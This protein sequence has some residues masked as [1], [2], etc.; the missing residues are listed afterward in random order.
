MLLGPVVS[1]N[2]T[3]VFVRESETQVTYA[4]FTLDRHGDDLNTTSLVTSNFGTLNLAIDVLVSQ[5]NYIPDLNEESTAMENVDFRLYSSDECSLDGERNGGGCVSFSPG[6][7]RAELRVEILPD[8]V[9]EGNEVFYLK[10]V[11]VRNGMRTRDHLLFSM[12]VT[13]IDGAQR[14]FRRPDTPIP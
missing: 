7:T 3:Q 9:L 1:F 5:V 12:T 11:Y 10:I 2:E 13:I 14:K 8:T 4:T 6:Q